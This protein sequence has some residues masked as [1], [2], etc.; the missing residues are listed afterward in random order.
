MC[1]TAAAAL[2]LGCVPSE[3]IFANGPVKLPHRF[4]FVSLLQLEEEDVSENCML[5]K[6]LLLRVLYPVHK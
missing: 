4:Q 1:D 5:G 6:V 2:Q 3:L